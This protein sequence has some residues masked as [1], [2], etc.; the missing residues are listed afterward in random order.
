MVMK[1]QLLFFVLMML[2]MVASAEFVEI[3]GI[4]YDLNT[5]G[6]V[7]EVVGLLNTNQSS[8]VIPE[9]VFSVF[10]VKNCLYF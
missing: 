8:V 9:T 7:A 10:C 2:P 6:K 3:D 1:K 5:D 4:Y